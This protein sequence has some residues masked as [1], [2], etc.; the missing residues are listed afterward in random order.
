[1][2]LYLHSAFMYWVKC[3]YIK[4]VKTEESDYRSLEAGLESCVIDLNS[5]STDSE[6]EVFVLVLYLQDAHEDSLQS[7]EGRDG[8]AALLFGIDGIGDR[9][10]RSRILRRVP[11]IRLTVG[12]N[13]GKT[14]PERKKSVRWPTKVTEDAVE[15]AR[16]SMQRGPNKSVKKLAVEIGV[17]Y[18]SAHKILRNKLVW[19]AVPFQ[20]K[21]RN[22]PRRGHDDDDDDDD[23]D[24]MNSNSPS[25]TIT[26][27]HDD[28]DDDDDDDLINGAK[29]SLQ[30]VLIAYI[31]P[32][33]AA[34][35]EH[36]RSFGVGEPSNSSP[37]RKRSLLKI[38][39]IEYPTLPVSFNHATQLY[40]VGSELMKI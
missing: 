6:Q 36:G 37:E 40:P 35:I 3:E 30:E 18:G 17:S 9:E 4:H 22:R 11:D 39:Q 15:D 31:K 5:D 23:D 12:E 14:E 27:M 24:N 16:E 20:R 38:N 13:L 33:Q 21:M 7:S 25:A 26:C 2:G 10:M 8:N 1:M 29:C 34:L 32:A 28:D 19:V